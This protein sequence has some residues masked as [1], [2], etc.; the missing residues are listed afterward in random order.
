[1]QRFHFVARRAALEDLQVHDKNRRKREDVVTESGSQGTCTIPR[2]F[3]TEA[4]GNCYT[5]D[6][7]GFV[8][9]CQ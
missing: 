6:R 9:A 7:R 8:S 5:F 1:M 3:T 2:A 4:H